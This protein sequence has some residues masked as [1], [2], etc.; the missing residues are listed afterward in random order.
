MSNIYEI[1][2]N[3][4]APLGYQVREQGSYGPAEQLPETFITYTYVDDSNDTHADNKPT[5]T[6]YLMRVILYSS[7]PV[8]IQNANDTLK[9]VMIPAGFLRA[10]GRRIPLEEES[11]KY[12]YSCDYRYYEEE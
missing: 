2:E 6:T 3:T 9:S 12:G 11:G 5:S 7:D 10:G 8:K 4:L 1:I